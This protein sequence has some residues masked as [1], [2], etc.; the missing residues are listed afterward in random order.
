MLFFP[1]KV[2]INAR[3]T[4]KIWIKLATVTPHEIEVIWYF[5]HQPM[6]DLGSLYGGLSPE[7]KQADG[8]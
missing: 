7:T 5:C 3:A 6:I 2:Y 8:N 4:C 1:V